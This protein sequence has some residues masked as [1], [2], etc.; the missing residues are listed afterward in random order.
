MIMNSKSRSL[1]FSH[2]TV[3]WQAILVNSSVILKRQIPHGG[4]SQL[5]LTFSIIQQTRNLPKKYISN[6]FKNQSQRAHYF[7]SHSTGQYLV[8]WPH[9]A[10]REAGR[11]RLQLGSHMPAKTLLS[12]EKQRM[13]I[14]NQL[15]VCHNF[16]HGALCY[17]VFRRSK[18]LDVPYKFISFHKSS[19]KF[20]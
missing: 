14:D 7:Y 18:I 6:S 15:K 2:V 20:Y 12:W 3:K 5:L 16:Q 1:F 13:D 10:A 11:C 9:L 4:P 8:T 17:A 19:L